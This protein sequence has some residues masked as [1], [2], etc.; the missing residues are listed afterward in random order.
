M[1]RAW[2]DLFKRL[3]NRTGITRAPTPELTSL[4][5]AEAYSLT[6]SA[7]RKSGSKF[8]EDL[9]APSS[10]SAS[11]TQNKTDR[12]NIPY[13]DDDTILRSPPPP[14][15]PPKSSARHHLP[16]RP[17]QPL[18]PHTSSMSSGPFIPSLY[19]S[20]TALPS[21]TSPTSSSP[22]AIHISISPPTNLQTSS[23]PYVRRTRNSSTYHPSR[24]VPCPPA[25][26]S[27]YASAPISPISVR[28]GWSGGSERSWRDSAISALD[29]VVVPEEGKDGGSKKG[30]AM[31]TGVLRR[32]GSAGGSGGLK[33][34]GPVEG[35][36]RHV[37]GAFVGKG[38]GRESSFLF[39]DNRDEDKANGS[40]N[41]RGI[42]VAS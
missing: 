11:T 38:K 19:P 20:S 13:T 36:F 6:S 22:P 7:A 16:P 31:G 8:V 39:G 12:S 40:G 1:L 23:L 42:G 28:S 32:G 27:D 5:N 17:C 2:I 34:S 21:P 29:K 4:D 30:K 37:D 25:H 14:Y 26:I 18:L 24:P 10:S 33:I 3:S 35:S 9:E 15:P 41:G